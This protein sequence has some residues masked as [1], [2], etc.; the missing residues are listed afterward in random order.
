MLKVYWLVTAIALLLGPTSN[1]YAQRDAAL[2]SIDEGADAYWAAA[3]QIWEWAEPG[4]QETKSSALLAGLLEEGGFRIEKGVAG[5]PT[6][7][8]A[9]FGSG[10]P[11][12][13]ILGEFDALPGLSQKATPEKSPDPS[14]EYGHACGHHLFGTASAAAA[15]ALAGQIEAGT[16]EGTIRFYGTPAEE[17]GGRGVPGIRLTDPF[18]AGS[19]LDA[20]GRAL[21]AGTADGGNGSAVRAG[22]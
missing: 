21:A 4:Y 22:A 5:I 14:R 12:I 3:L 8:T 10:R 9:T 20:V 17:G 19:L 13:G 16:L 18:S 11:V 1:V 15:L 7:F 2:R 6:A